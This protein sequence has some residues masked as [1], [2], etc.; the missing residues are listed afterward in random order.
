MEKLAE[1]VELL[2]STPEDKQTAAITPTAGDKQTAA[3]TPTA[4]DKQTAAITPTEEDKDKTPITHTPDIKQAPIP[5]EGIRE[6]GITT[7][8]SN[9][10]GE[11]RF[12]AQE[13]HFATEEKDPITAKD[14]M[15]HIIIDLM[16][17][18]MVRGP[19]RS[20]LHNGGYD[21]PH[22]I[23]LMQPAS[24]FT[25]R[26]IKG[27]PI[28]EATPLPQ[29]A[30]NALLNLQAYHA[31]NHMSLADHDHE[32]F[33][34]WNKWMKIT[35]HDLMIFHLET[36]RRDARIE[37]WTQ[38]QLHGQYRET[39]PRHVD[40]YY[41]QNSAD[42]NIPKSVEH[43]NNQDEPE[44]Q[45][46]G[47]DDDEEKAPSHHAPSETDSLNAKI[48]NEVK[49]RS[50]NS[51]LKG[52]R[53]DVNAYKE[54]K[55]DR[56]YDSWIKSIR[57]NAKLHGVAPVLDKNYQPIGEEAI[58][59]FDDMQT[60]M[61][62]IVVNT[63]KTASGKQLIRQHDGDAQMVFAKLHN[64]LKE[65]QKAE[66]S[67]DDLH[68][69]IKEL[70]ISKWTGTYVSFLE[71][72]STQLFLWCELV[73]GTRSEPKE[74]EKKKMLKTSVSTISVMASIATQEA[75]DIAKGYKKWTYDAYYDILMKQAIDDDRAKKCVSKGTKT[76]SQLNKAE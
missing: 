37:N 74:N 63:I 41:R 45:R 48:S 58:D 24:L 68:D 49:P 70:S 12:K 16:H 65:S 51:V 3:I 13:P 28:I 60:Y 66:F 40:D 15:E 57:A 73:A 55:E 4:E 9:P 52:I 31:A 42:S 62:A 23:I 26:S 43:E 59:E 47:R 2:S 35:Y 32:Y 21:Q 76:Q 50:K 34:D 29:Q 1:L 64:E 27:D 11:N 18:T 6:Q 17:E 67:G 56:F 44:Q 10:K 72:W 69:K 5:P 38:E 22:Q 8:R 46:N 39:S 33:L 19:I 30:V 71:H 20:A 61:W 75:I 25:N 36:K 53:R 54:L 7:P 14:V